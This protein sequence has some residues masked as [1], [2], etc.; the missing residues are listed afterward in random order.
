MSTD[1][2][3]EPVKAE[4]KVDNDF[5]NIKRVQLAGE[6]IRKTPDIRAYIV[7]RDETTKVAQQKKAVIYASELAWHPVGVRIVAGGRTLVVPFDRIE[8]IELE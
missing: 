8:V 4:A 3:T 7:E 2:K 1:K 5:R 6:G